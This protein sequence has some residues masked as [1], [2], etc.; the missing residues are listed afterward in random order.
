MDMDVPTPIERMWDLP[1]MPKTRKITQPPI[2]EM[3]KVI[4]PRAAGETPG[5]VVMIVSADRSGRLKKFDVIVED[6]PGLGFAQSLKSA[7]QNSI[8]FA[9]KVDGENVPYSFQLN[10]E[11]C[12]RCEKESTIK[13]VSGDI[14]VGGVG[15]R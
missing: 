2:L 14:Q 3:A 6:P 4:Y 7:L 1:G 15:G 8:F 12:W 9:P 5:T 13:V 10:Y 11:F